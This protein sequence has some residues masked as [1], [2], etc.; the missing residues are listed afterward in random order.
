VNTDYTAGEVLIDIDKIRP[1]PDNPRD[2]A[3]DISELVQSIREHG[4][5]QSLLL[6]EDLNRRSHYVIEAG[7]RRWT[8]ARIAGIRQVPA[9]IW[10]VSARDISAN[11]AAEHALIIGLVENL[12]REDLNA[13]E[14]ARA[15]GKLRSRG[16]TQTQIAKATGTTVS[17]VSRFL[18]LLELSRASQDRVRDGR[19][20][21]EEALAAVKRTRARERTK[22]GHK[23][24]DIGWDP[25]HFTRHHSLARK[26]ATMCEARGHNNRRRIHDSNACEQCWETVIRQDEAVVQRAELKS[27]G[28][29]APFNPPIFL[30][31]NGTGEEVR[32]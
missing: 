32:K 23:P 18:A 9:R 14:R 16:M 8:A 10:S 2:E 26:A 21:V 29:D 12:H 30:A 7:F 6:R 1:N 4:I 17:T 19:V 24:I 27:A 13:I 11:T 20:G 25:P 5:L 3:G 15:Y 28:I 22:Q 31:D